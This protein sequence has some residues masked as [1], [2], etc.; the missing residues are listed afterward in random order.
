LIKINAPD[1]VAG[2]ENHHD[3]NHYHSINRARFLAWNCHHGNSS[4]RRSPA[5]QLGARQAPS[6]GAFL[7]A[8]RAEAIRVG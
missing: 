2:H 4:R 3:L 1:R 8:L 5:A 7:L 6:L